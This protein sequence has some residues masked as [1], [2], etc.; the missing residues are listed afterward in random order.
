MPLFRALAERGGAKARPGRRRQRIGDCWRTDE[1][2]P[3]LSLRQLSLL[4][5]ADNMKKVWVKDYTDNYLDQ[6]SFR[7]IMGPFN[8]L[9]ELIKK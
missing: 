1:D 2:G 4:S 7:Y 9:S 8:L 6:Y 3:V 5:L